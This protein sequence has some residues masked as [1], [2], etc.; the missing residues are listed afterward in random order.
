MNQNEFV[1]G[2]FQG[3]CDLIQNQG[4]RFDISF[5]NNDNFDKDLVTL[6][7]SERIQLVAYLTK[8]FIKG[9]FTGAGGGIGLIS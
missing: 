4:I 2:D 1:L 3:A 7:I 8:A 9:T 6:K 5:E